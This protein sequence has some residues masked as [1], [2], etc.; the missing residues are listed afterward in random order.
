MSDQLL[1]D[2][3]LMILKSTVEVYVHGT[4]EA[5]NKDIKELLKH[6]LDETLSHQMRCYNEMTKN[7]WYQINN[8]KATEIAKTLKTICEKN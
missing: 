8:V 1:L 5:S 7:G 6:G 2:N 4:L 3:Y